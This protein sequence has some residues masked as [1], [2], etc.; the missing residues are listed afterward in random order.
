MSTE[1]L[2]GAEPWSHTASS[3]DGASTAGFLAL[4]G[5]TGNPS[6]MRGV[7]EHVAGAG[8]H[9]ELPRL[10]GHGTAVED[11]IPTRWA[12]W[13]GEVE[14]AYQRLTERVERIVVGG[15]SM[16]GSLSL[17]TGLQH[18]EVSGLV[19][20][21]PATTSQGPEVNEMLRAAVA[22]GTELMPGIGSDIADPDAVEIAYEGTPLRALLSLLDDGLAPMAER[23]GEL[24]M[25]LLLYTSRQDHVV[26]PSQSE[27]LAEHYGGD[28]DHHWLDRSFHVATQDFDRETIFAGTVDFIR[29]VTAR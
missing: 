10:P 16:G 14:A 2:A 3:A 7:A 19:C 29:R 26:E 4:H 9:V 25:P 20:V 15:L 28:V 27:Y 12:D 18:P 23:Y 6:S 13:A 5:F 22:E 1:I 21:N 24:K 8:Y 17:W 11:M